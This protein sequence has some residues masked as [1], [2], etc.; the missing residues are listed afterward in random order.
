[1]PVRGGK[2]TTAAAAEVAAA[3]ARG[4]ATRARAVA[5][6]GKHE[7]GRDAVGKRGKR[8]GDGDS[9]RVFFGGGAGEV[10][11][12]APTRARAVAVKEEPSEQAM[13]VDGAEGANAD[14]EPGTSARTKDPTVVGAQATPVR[15]VRMSK[16]KQAQLAMEEASKKIQPD[17]MATE[18]MH[19]AEDDWVDKSQYYPTVLKSAREM[20]VA[21]VGEVVKSSTDDN[22]VVLQLPSYLPLRKHGGNEIM[23]VDGVVTVADENS[24]EHTNSEDNDIVRDLS[25]LS[26]G[27]LGELRIHAD[28]SAKLYIGNAVFDVMHG[29]P[30]QHAEQVVR[31]DSENQQCVIMGTSSAR[32]TCVPDVTALLL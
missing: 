10:A 4:S 16:A 29:T 13:E 30:Y 1:M 20:D 24:D 15:Q 11:G 23:E 2:T 22:Y 12:T 6:V 26:E 3:A 14:A 21:S 19:D 28:G 7:R 8:V 31:L 25:E 9:S 27:Q 18:Q 17:R 32:L 5:A